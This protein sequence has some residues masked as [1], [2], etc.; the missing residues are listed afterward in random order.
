MI[1]KLATNG[2][3]VHV[4]RHAGDLRERDFRSASPL[5]ITEM[6]LSRQLARPES[7]RR[8]AT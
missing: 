2:L 6:G 1:R 3:R 8:E 7:L 5:Q 4:A